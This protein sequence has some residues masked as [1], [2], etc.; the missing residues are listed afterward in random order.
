[1]TEGVLV[2]IGEGVTLVP[3]HVE[4]LDEIDTAWH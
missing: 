4:L 1:M 3:L 2:F